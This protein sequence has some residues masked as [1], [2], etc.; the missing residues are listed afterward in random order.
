MSWIFGAVHQI[1]HVSSKVD[2]D[3]SCRQRAG[4]GPF[5]FVGKLHLEYYEFNGQESMPDCPVAI[6]FSAAI[7]L[8]FIQEQ[9]PSACHHFFGCH[10]AGPQHLGIRIFDDDAAIEEAVELGY[11]LNSRGLGRGPA[12]FLFRHV[13]QAGRLSNG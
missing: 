9:A 3:V 12:F 5:K 8:E 6:G 13:E 2:Q 10:G 7:E 11:A 4:I 1:G